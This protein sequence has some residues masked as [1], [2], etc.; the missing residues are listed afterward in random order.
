M[1]TSEAQIQNSTPSPGPWEFARNFGPKD[2]IEIWHNAD[3]V[4]IVSN[5]TELGTLLANARLIVAAPDLL[6]AL[7]RTLGAFSVLDARHRLS[8]KSLRR[9]ETPLMRRGGKR[10]EPGLTN[11]RGDGRS[12]H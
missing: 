5:Q 11:D 2:D 6:A 3:L 9:R 4:A 8:R 7:Q 10:N 1:T 12:S